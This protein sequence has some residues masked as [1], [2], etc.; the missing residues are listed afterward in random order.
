MTSKEDILRTARKAGP[1][2]SIPFDVWCERFAELVIKPWADQLEVERKRFQELNDVVATGMQ[3]ARAAEREACAKVCESLAGQQ[4]V[5]REAALE[6]SDAIRA[7]GQ[8]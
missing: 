8:A 3:H 6:C 1:L 4:W 7:R 2:I 5:T